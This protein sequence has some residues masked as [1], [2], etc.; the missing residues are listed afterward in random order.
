MH[1]DPHGI[2]GS[3]VNFTFR[4]A[5]CPPL[6]R[7]LAL[8]RVGFAVILSDALYRSTVLH[9]YDGLEPARFWPAQ[10]RVKETEAVGWLST[11]G[12]EDCARQAADQPRPE[13]AAR[14]AD[15]GVSI[16]AGGDVSMRRSKVIGR[17]LRLGGSAPR[18]S[19][20]RG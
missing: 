18:N 3:D 5:D 11:P 16:S 6:K 1:T 10:V 14:P 7:A 9:R 4:L 2:A 13:P 8:S 20:K 15:G 12:E 19:A 17:D